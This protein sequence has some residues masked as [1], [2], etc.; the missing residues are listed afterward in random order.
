MERP[1][2]KWQTITSLGDVDGNGV[3][4]AEDEALLRILRR[5]NSVDPTPQQLVAGDLNG[6]GRI[7]RQDLVLLKRLLRG[8][9]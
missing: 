3:L 2:S 5:K 4:N 7:G 6:D 9:D 1:L 8:L